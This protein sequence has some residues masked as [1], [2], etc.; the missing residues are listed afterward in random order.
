MSS[1]SAC[2]V[3]RNEEAVIERCLHSLAGVVDEIVLIHDGE[4]TDRTLE[5]AERFGARI[6]VA[7]HAGGNEPHL[8]FAF[9]L[10]TGEWLL[11]LDADEFLSPELRA[12]L[13]GLTA[14]TDV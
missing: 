11:R 6:T 9:A 13:P 4:C 14:R 12:A 2:L 8:P 3:V 10:A 5:I 1:I 7:D